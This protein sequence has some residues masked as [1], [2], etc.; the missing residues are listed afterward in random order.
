MP[1]PVGFYTDTT[2]CI[3]CKACQV[4][5]HQWNDLP[6]EH[7]PNG[8]ELPMLSGNSY[9][10]TG[11]LSAVN[12]R[13]VKFIEQFSPDAN[14]TQAAWLMMSDVCKHCKEAPCLEVCPTGAILR[15]EFDTVYINPPACNGC[16]DC[17]S[18]CPF[19]VIH[20]NAGGIAQKCTFCYDRLKHGLTPA[21]AQACPTQS[22]RFGPLTKLKKEAAARVAQL[23]GQGEIKAHLYGA[24][25]TIL[26]GL[27]AFY[28]L[29]DKPETYGLPAAAKLPSRSVPLSSLWG[30]AVAVLTGLGMLFTFRRRAVAASVPS[31]APTDPLHPPI[32]SPE[33][34]EIQPARGEGEVRP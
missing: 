22:I 23:Q 31:V 28:V 1:D 12:W 32:Q 16:R 4:A 7:G 3:G 27:N 6:A 20:M 14:R 26:G 11:S 15:T 19:G 29:V 30:I 24:D 18:A 2:V 13:H 33:R 10:N 5:C 21:C 34:G 17:V 9:D 25:D 8:R